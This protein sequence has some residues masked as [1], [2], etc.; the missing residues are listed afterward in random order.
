M[1]LFVGYVNNVFVMVLRD[2][3][4]SGIVVKM[5]K[6]QEENFIVGKKQICILVDGFKVFVLIVEVFIDMLFLKGQY[7]VWC[8]ENFVY[9]LIVG[10]VLDVKLVD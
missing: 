5:S 3:G 8:M 9:D 2:I 1:F 7:E 10:N 4:C 6:I